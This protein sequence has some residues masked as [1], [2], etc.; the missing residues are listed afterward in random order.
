MVESGLCRLL[1]SAGLV[2]WT[3]GSCSHYVYQILMPI[4]SAILSE[5]EM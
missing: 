1:S 2:G 3:M 5:C 4:L